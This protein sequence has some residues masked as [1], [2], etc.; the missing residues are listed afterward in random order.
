MSGEK[1]APEAV[2]LL[3]GELAALLHDVSRQLRS[4][5]HAEVN[6]VPLPDSERD[7]LR[8]VG[9][10]PGSGVGV[11]ARELHMKSSNVSAAVRN[12]VARDLMIREADPGDRRIARLTLTDQAYRNLER[13]Q[14]SWDAHLGAALGRLEPGDREKLEGAV[15]ALRALVQVLRGR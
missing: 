2:A 7:V 15:P 5:A 8:Y 1:T 9:R 3:S 10:N 13:L 6:L 4:A 12:L 14:R 11:V